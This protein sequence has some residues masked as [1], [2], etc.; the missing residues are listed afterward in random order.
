MFNKIKNFSK[1]LAWHI[2]NGM[3]KSTQ[4]EIDKR[5]AIC[6]SCS[7]FD[8]KNNECTVCGCN[9]NNQKIFMNK[10]AWKDSQC[11]LNRW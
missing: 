10:L 3:P 1:H 6:K 5:Y 4:D 2:G 8:E 11:P 7:S 9:V